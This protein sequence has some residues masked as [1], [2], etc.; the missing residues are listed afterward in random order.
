[1]QLDAHA[2]WMQVSSALQ[3]TP[4]PPQFSLSLAVRA[5]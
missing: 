4:Q 5:Q 3:W 1:M 2:P